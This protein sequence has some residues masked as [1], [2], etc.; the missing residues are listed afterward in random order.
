[1]NTFS[2]QLRETTLTN[3]GH[4][5]GGGGTGGGGGGGG[6]NTGGGGGNGGTDVSSYSTHSN[7]FTDAEGEYHSLENP[8]H[9][10]SSYIENSPEFYP[11]PPSSN[12]AEL[13]FH[14]QFN[15]KNY[16]RTGWSYVN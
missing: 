5:A 1:M 13:K 16:H 6:G 3:H 7:P 15:G 9:Q 10:S 4:G 2:P 8:A 14:H 11:V 12:L